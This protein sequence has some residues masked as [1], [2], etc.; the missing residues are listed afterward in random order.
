M[1]AG[2]LFEPYFHMSSACD[3]RKRKLTLVKQVSHLR[4]TEVDSVSGLFTAERGS[5]VQVNMPTV[6]RFTPCQ[7]TNKSF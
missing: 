1:M 2:P 7:K 5:G 6:E 3:G 4:A